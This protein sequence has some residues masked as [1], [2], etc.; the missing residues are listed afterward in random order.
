MIFSPPEPPRGAADIPHTDGIAQ[1][2][3]DASEGN[4][5]G[6]IPWF[7]LLEMDELPDLFAG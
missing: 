3:I 6:V 5:A 7:D 2:N 1:S 4:D